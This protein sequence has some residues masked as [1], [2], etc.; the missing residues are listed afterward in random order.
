MSCYAG[1]IHTGPSLQLQNQQWPNTHNADKHTVRR[2]RELP[3]T[4]I[5]GCGGDKF[6]IRDV[7]CLKALKADDGGFTSQ[8]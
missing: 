1:A 4:T 6:Q 7:T 2:N 8:Q 5:E 3:T